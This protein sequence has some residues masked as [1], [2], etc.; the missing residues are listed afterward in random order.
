MRSRYDGER[1]DLPVIDDCSSIIKTNPSD[2]HQCP[3][4]L[5]LFNKEHKCGENGWSCTVCGISLNKQHKVSLYK[6]QRM[7][8]FGFKKH[9]NIINA[10]ICHNCAI[11]IAR[12]LKD[13][14]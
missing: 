5:Q 4:C 2:V 8:S 13:D 6:G 14:K 1:I 7:W 10:V 3:K 9:Y 12:M 11:K